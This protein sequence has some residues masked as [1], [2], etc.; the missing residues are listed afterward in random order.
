MGEDL[1]NGFVEQDFQLYEILLH[2]RYLSEDYAFLADR[3]EEI[4]ECLSLIRTR[5]Y[6]VA[7]A[8]EFK[9]GKSTLLNALLGAK[10]LPA[11][12][13]PTTATVNRITYGTEPAVRIC[14]RDGTESVCDIQEL[15]QYVTKSTEE[16]E[17]IAASV[18]EAVVYYPTVLCQNHIDVI[19]TPGLN[20]DEK[21]T[22]VTAEVFRQVDAVIFT[23]SALAPLSQFETEWILKLVERQ[24]IEHLIFVMTYADCLEEEELGEMKEFLRSRAAATALLA[25]QR[26]EGD[27]LLIEK[28]H[29]ILDHIDL[30]AVSSTQALEAFQTGDNELLKRSGF[31]VFKQEL[32]RIL[33]AR[34]GMHVSV[35]TERLLLAVRQEIRHLIAAETDRILRK[36]PLPFE[37][38]K[39]IDRN[40]LLL[41]ADRV[42]A[43]EFRQ[44]E[45][46][47]S[48]E[49]LF[50]RLWQIYLRRLASVNKNRD[51]IIFKALNKATVEGIQA[52]QLSFQTDG[53]GLLAF[54]RKAAE[55]CIQAWTEGLCRRYGFVLKE[56]PDWGRYCEELMPRFQGRPFPLFH[57]VRPMI[58]PGLLS[59]TDVA[60]HVQREIINSLRQW[61]AEREKYN[62]F[63]RKTVFQYLAEL[64]N[65]WEGI[66]KQAEQAQLRSREAELGENVERYRRHE[67][68]LEQYL[69]QVVRMRGG[70]PE[71]QRK[72]FERR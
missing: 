18:R 24:E 20:D 42:M 45:R 51:D 16:Q 29:R 4:E 34:Q 60:P 6:E 68:Q 72:Q 38:D 15:N 71:N 36:Y 13:T 8:G 61:S 63:F 47:F 67:K 46:L 26:F 22:A 7:V 54:Y 55:R 30:F 21:M 52:M 57:W 56:Y 2:L 32:Y 5:K 58:P 48:E 1:D 44:M 35:R 59:Q 62:E 39:R 11:K 19:D 33:T 9:R 64:I 70:S 41:A 43:E 14:Y 28:A 66:L 65:R 3:R 23:V 27:E 10:I 17:K 53:Q 25:E 40:G 37:R 50:A 49:E 12:C 31:P 69:G